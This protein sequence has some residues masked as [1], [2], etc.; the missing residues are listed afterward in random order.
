MEIVFWCV[1]F[2]IC[3][4]CI[5]RFRSFWSKV[6]SVVY[7]TTVQCQYFH[8]INPLN[9]QL[10]IIKRGG[11]KHKEL[12]QLR[13]KDMFLMAAEWGAFCLHSSATFCV[14]WHKI[15]HGKIHILSDTCL[16]FFCPCYCAPPGVIIKMLL[17]LTSWILGYFCGQFSRAQVTKSSSFPPGHNED[18]V[19]AGDFN[20]SS[21]APWTA[22]Q[23]Q[24][25]LCHHSHWGNVSLVN[26]AR[27]KQNYSECTNYTQGHPVF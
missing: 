9:P 8:I 16:F 1:V 20:G 3:V 5:I 22:A 15:Q 27:E 17:P 2:A 25:S 4:I 19:S 21:S 7:T 6:H 23:Y 24:R 13:S 10:D 11:C 26:K 12:F 18:T 14:L